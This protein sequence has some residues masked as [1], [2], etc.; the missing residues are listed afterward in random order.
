M[1]HH[2]AQ[3]R[4][5]AA[6]RV[7][8]TVDEHSLTV[9]DVDPGIGDLAMNAQ[10]HACLSHC[11]QHRHHPVDVA[12][13]GGR[14]GGRPGRIEFTAVMMPSRAAATRSAASVPSVR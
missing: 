6:Q 7:E 12:H 3:C 2:D 11:L 4:Q 10:R 1:F 9:E 13:A 14:A 5:T 8:D